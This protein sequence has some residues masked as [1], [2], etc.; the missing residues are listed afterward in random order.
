MEL[1][2]KTV[3]EARKFKPLFAL[4]R[5]KRYPLN[6]TPIITRIGDAG[7]IALAA[8]LK[9]PSCHLEA[10]G[11]SG[12]QLTDVAALAFARVLSRGKSHDGARET[13]IYGQYYRQ[14]ANGTASEAGGTSTCTLRRLDLSRNGV[15]DTGARCVFGGVFY[16]CRDRVS[17][18]SR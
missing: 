9:I 13:R 15:T 7:A 5:L 18:S 16:Y 4:L 6:D 17:F 8:A 12:A 14:R 2:S 3:L 11:L 1:P 10:L